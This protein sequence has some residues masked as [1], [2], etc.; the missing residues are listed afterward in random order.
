MLLTLFLGVEFSGLQLFEY[1]IREFTIR[2]RRFGTIFY[3]TTGFH[4]LHV[5]I[6][7]I[8]LFIC[9]LRG[10]SLNFSSSHHFGFLAAI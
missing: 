8:F 1:K 9:L 6:G 4:G 7:R 3:V 5:L 10:L 2:D